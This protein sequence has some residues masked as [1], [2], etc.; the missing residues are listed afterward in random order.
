VTKVHRLKAYATTNKPSIASANPKETAMSIPS[1]PARIGVIGGGH[2]GRIHA[3]LIAANPNCELVGVADPSQESR[4][5][6]ATQLNTTTISDYQVWQGKID[7]AIIAAPTF[8]HHQIGSWCLSNGIHVFMEKPIAS[9]LRQA[10]QLIHL[11]QS[12]D[13]TLQVGHVERFNPAWQFAGAGLD[14]DSIRYIEAAREGT[15]TGRSTDI[16]IVMDLMIHDIDLVLSIVPSPIVHVQAYGWSV[17][18]EHEDFAAASV[19]FRNGTTAQFRAS[20]LSPTPRRS[21]QVYTTEGLTEIDFASGTVQTISPH[22]DVADGTRQADKL[23]AQERTEVKERLYS[24]WLNKV[25]T[26]VPATNAIEH[27]HAEFLR[28]IAVGAPVTVTGSHG[29]KALELASRIL[30]QIASSGP[31]RSIIP[32]ADRFGQSKAA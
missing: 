15:Y 14:P 21:M 16:G 28:G 19:Q 5:A 12:N 1:N 31:S 9:T 2:L 27:E 32:S 22:A 26:K 23:P 24:D 18:G 10:S 25:E 17:L 13:L 20:R 7:G 29:C 4:K 30:D 3:K 6:V 11:A 8:L